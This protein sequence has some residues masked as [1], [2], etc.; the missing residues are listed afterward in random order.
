MLR[1]AKRAYDFVVID[2]PPAF[3]EHVLAAFDVSDI[4]ILIATLDIPA[5]KNLRL[6]LDTLDLLGNP[7]DSRVVVL[8]R[9]DA[10]VGLRAEDVVAAI[11]TDIAE[12]VP[13]SPA[14]PASVNRGVPLVLDEP[15]H[16]VSLAIRQLTDQHIRTLSSSD[17]AG[18][19]G[20]RRENRKGDRKILSWGGK[21]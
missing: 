2:T 11:K 14:V 15:R 19:P 17:G 9:S 18:E 13:S 4:L 3:T 1:V 7:R 8:N 16:P 12:Q 20:E 21:K 6:T 10:K 5:V